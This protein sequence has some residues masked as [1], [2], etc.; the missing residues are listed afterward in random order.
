[1]INP[2]SLERTEELTQSNINRIETLN[3]EADL[4]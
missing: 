2:E 1:M 3:T 4:K